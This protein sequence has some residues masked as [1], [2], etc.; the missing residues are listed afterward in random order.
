MKYTR[1]LILAMIACATLLTSGCTIGPRVETRIVIVRNDA[2]VQVIESR[3]VLVMVTKDGTV[4]Q[5]KVDIGGYIAMPPD[6]FEKMRE[7]ARIGLT[8]ANAGK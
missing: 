6:A 3:K 7:L 5:D 4:F 8:H 2:T 1:T